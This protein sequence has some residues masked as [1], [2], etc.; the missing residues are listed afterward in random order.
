MSEDTPN[1]LAAHLATSMAGSRM[2]DGNSI[3]SWGCT[4]ISVDQMPGGGGSGG[5]G[6]CL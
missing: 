5:G 4:Q 6:R 2:D 1:Y 3:P